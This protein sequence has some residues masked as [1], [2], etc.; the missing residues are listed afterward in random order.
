MAT[1]G[2]TIKKAVVAVLPL[3]GIATTALGFG[4]GGV[5]PGLG[6]TRG[7]GMTLITGKVLC[8]QCSLEEVR[9]SQPELEKLYQLTGAQGHVVMQFRSVNGPEVWRFPGP[10]QFSVR[11]KASVFQ[12][13]TTE[14]HLLKDVEIT[15]VLSKDARNLDIFDVTILG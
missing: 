10:P 2:T 11:S 8:A 7:A 13:L 5:G 14:E 3:I 4:P 9:Q 1:F 6:G 15:S 12:Q